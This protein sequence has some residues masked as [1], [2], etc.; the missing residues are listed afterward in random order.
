[1]LTISVIVQKGGTGK[2]T[3][4]RCLAVAFERSGKKAAIVDM[5]P[6]VTASLWGK[7]RQAEHPEVIP[8]AIPLLPDVLEEAKRSVD[9]AIIDT[10]PKSADAVVAA[11]KVADLIVIPCTPEIDD[12][13]TLPATKQIIDVTRRDAGDTR[14]WPPPF[15]VVLNLVTPNPQRN[16]EAKAKITSHKNAPL[17]VCP[18]MLG[19][20]VAYGDASILGMTPQEYEPKGLAAQEI[21]KVHKYV[22]E[23]VRKLR[24]EQNGT[25][26]HT[27][28]RR[29][30]TAKT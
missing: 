20:R 21:D 3:V 14:L 9:V 11:A 26:K 4:S 5:D 2:T 27:G 8:T 29:A 16:E 19:D 1:M 10:P 18:Y 22:C 24:S 30:K 15:F 13:E 23:I 28:S 7:R 25:S 6:Q 12:I 17:P